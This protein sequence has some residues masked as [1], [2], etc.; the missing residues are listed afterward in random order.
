MRHDSDRGVL[1]RTDEVL[2][3]AVDG[4]VYGTF[5]EPRSQHHPNFVPTA[6]QLGYLRLSHSR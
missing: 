6:G 4:F 2:D 5:V 1:P 3:I